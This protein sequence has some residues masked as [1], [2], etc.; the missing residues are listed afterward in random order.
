MWD[1]KADNEMLI[2]G[3]ELTESMKDIDTSLAPYPFQHY[4]K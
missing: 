2:E 1:Y 3:A 4:E